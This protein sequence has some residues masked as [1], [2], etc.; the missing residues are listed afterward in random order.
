VRTARHA[1][2]AEV[3]YCDFVSAGVSRVPFLRI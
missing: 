3:A 2:G 1:R